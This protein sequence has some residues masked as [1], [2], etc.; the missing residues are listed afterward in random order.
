MWGINNSFPTT[1]CWMKS[2]GS[3]CG[4]LF[5]ESDSCVIFLLWR[6][7][8]LIMYHGWLPEYLIWVGIGVAWLDCV[9]FSFSA[10]LRLSFVSGCSSFQCSKT[11]RLFDVEAI[12]SRRVSGSANGCQNWHSWM[13]HK[14]KVAKFCRLV[15]LRL[16]DAH[17]QSVS[18]RVCPTQLE[19]AARDSVN[20]SL[21]CSQYWQLHIDQ[22]WT[23]DKNRH[24]FVLKERERERCWKNEWEGESGIERVILIYGHNAGD[25]V[26]D[27]VK[28]QTPSVCLL[29]GRQIITCNHALRHEL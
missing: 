5:R 23:K 12:P 3:H 7:E 15:A 1:G 19:E 28:N 17:T 18:V 14:V 13:S 16:K 27:F 11:S 8:E 10:M 4:R 24:S 29:G 25:F 20:F 2:A 9:F 6:Q 22:S 26:F 21:V